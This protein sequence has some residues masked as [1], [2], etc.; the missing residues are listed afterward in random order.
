[1]TLLKS[2]N[3]F[4]KQIYFGFDSLSSRLMFDLINLFVT[5]LISAQVPH[6]FVK[7][8][9]SASYHKYYKDQLCICMF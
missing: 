7:D 6:L 3:L 2:F 9:S 8:P 4:L 5:F 1:M